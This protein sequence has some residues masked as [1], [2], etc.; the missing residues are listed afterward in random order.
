MIRS[1]SGGYRVKNLA[2]YSPPRD[3]HYGA[4]SFF[5]LA[6][7]VAAGVVVQ[8]ITTPTPFEVL[9]GASALALVLAGVAFL[10]PVWSAV[11]PLAVL[12]AA[13]LLLFP[14]L[15]LTPLAAGVGLGVLLSPALQMVEHWNK[16]VVLRLGK[17]RRVRGPGL[18]I[19]LP[20]VER[21]ARVVDTG[22]RA[23]DFSAE[24]TLTSDSVPAHV[25]A[26]T[27]WMIWDAKLGFYRWRTSSRQWCSQ[28]R[29]HYA[30]PSAS[31]AWLSC[32]P[33]ESESARRF[34]SCSMPRLIRGASRYCPSSLPTSS[35]RRRWRTRCRVAPRQSGRASRG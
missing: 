4:L 5:A 17:F 34:S 30:T 29:P 11:V 14:D 18:H 7:L 6:A 15:D 3:F 19:L 9:A 20:V 31:P 12:S 22:I 16:A 21:V 10:L 25:D 1:E 8:R 28:L 13:G 35:S 24:K 23:T 32:S 26:L 2:R 33:S 27:F